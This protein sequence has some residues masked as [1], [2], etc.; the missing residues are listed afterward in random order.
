MMRFD[1][2]CLVGSIIKDE[3]GQMLLPGFVHRPP[4]MDILHL[5]DQT[6]PAA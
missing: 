1:P 3:K 2:L 6:A 5:C 4:L